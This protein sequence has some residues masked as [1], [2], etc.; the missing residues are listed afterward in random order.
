MVAHSL[1][2]LALAA[3]LASCGKVTVDYDNRPC[4]PAATCIDGYVCN[5]ISNICDRITE[6]CNQDIDDDGVAD[7]IDGCIDV[8]GDGFGLPGGSGN[9]CIAPDCEDRLGFATCNINCTNDLDNDAVVD[10]L[11]ACIDVD[12]DGYGINGGVGTCSGAD[13]DESA[14]TCTTDCIT[15]VDN[16]AV[17]DCR[18]AC[19]DRD[20]DN[21]GTAGGGG[22]T[23]LGVDCDDN[24][25]PN[26]TTNCQLD[27][28]NDTI[29]DCRDGCID[30]DNDGYGFPGGG[31]NTCTGS[32][33]KDNDLACTTDCT[34]CPPT[35]LTVATDNPTASCGTAS[36]TVDLDGYTGATA[37]L[38]CSTSSV[39]LPVADVGDA[40]RIAD[41]N[42]SDDGW[43]AG[44]GGQGWSRR[45]WGQDSGDYNAS[46]PTSGADGY[47]RSNSNNTRTLE[48]NA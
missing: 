40:D 23:C 46:C 2:H 11:D 15:N 24:N 18:D 42:G 26:C 20:G 35:F 30:S 7:C 33:C 6:R 13:C 12:G 29:P 25:A 16:D 9:T 8:D 27:L 47:W 1:K 34:A 45:T 10:C 36:L 32:D 3:V 31:A 37:Q 14:D 28:D 44:P 48:P 17:P 38:A 4:G 19:I 21:F 43:S 22:N 41:F 5:P 39:D